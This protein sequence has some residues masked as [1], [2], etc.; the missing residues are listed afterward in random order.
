MTQRVRYPRTSCIV[1]FCRRT[2]TVMPGEWVCGEHWRLVDRGLK[3]VR[4]R[5]IRRWR[6]NG[7]WDA[8]DHAVDRTLNAIW[9]RMKRQAIER[10]SGVGG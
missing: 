3:R 1:P 5:L 10:A 2:S 9:R 4:T 6:R 7:R 8:P